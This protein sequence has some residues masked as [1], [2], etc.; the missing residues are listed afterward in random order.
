MHNRI[1]P[2][3]KEHRLTIEWLAQC[4]RNRQDIYILWHCRSESILCSASNNLRNPKI[5]LILDKINLWWVWLAGSR[6]SLFEHL[7][8]LSFEGSHMS[9]HGLIYWFCLYLLDF[10]CE[11]WLLDILKIYTHAKTSSN[12]ICKQFITLDQNK[13]ILPFKTFG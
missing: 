7:I 3:A 11:K 2:I 5:V 4:H 1:K 9:W 6:C 8:S 13:V 12:F 10:C